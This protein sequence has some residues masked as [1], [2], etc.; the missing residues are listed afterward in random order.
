[1]DA[2]GGVLEPHESGVRRLKAIVAG[3]EYVAYR[4]LEDARADPDAAV[5]F[6]GDHGGQVYLTCPVRHVR[7]DEPVL[8][9]L[10]ADL[11]RLGWEDP[12]GARMHFERRPVGADVPGGM[13]EAGVVDGP[14]LH[15]QI[16]SPALAA[17]VAAVLA[18]ERAAL[19]LRESRRVVWSTEDL[20]TATPPEGLGLP[21]LSTD[22]LDDVLGVLADGSPVEGS[23][24]VFGFGSFVLEVVHPS[25]GKATLLVWPALARLAFDGLARDATLDFEPELFEHERLVALL[26]GVVDR[27]LAV[28]VVGDRLGVDGSVDDAEL[29]VIVMTIDEEGAADATFWSPD[30]L[31]VDW[32]SAQLGP[33]ER[34]PPVRGD[35]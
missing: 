22:L 16:D 8:R 20:S 9:S 11:D 33:V 35:G 27:G 17:Q 26:R 3:E 12:G 6:E 15:A 1:M 25:G 4:S 29:T 24:A 10:L 32:L 21:A 31:S 30:T 2:D 28:R 18:G 5:V 13:G 14:W 34:V 7:C 19:D 23:I